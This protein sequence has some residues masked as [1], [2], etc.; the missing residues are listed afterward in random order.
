MMRCRRRPH[1]RTGGCGSYSRTRTFTGVR[2]DRLLAAL[3]GNQ[4][5]ELADALDAVTQANTTML[6]YYQQRLAAFPR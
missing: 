4:A 6:G 3:P 5:G 2:E 1:R